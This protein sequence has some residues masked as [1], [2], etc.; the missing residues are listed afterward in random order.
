MVAVER[1]NMVLTEQPA[2]NKERKTL[3]YNQIP[4]TCN[5]PYSFPLCSF[6]LT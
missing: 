6:A 2:K 4:T 5:E 3:S 1:V